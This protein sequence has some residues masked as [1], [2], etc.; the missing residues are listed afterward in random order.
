LST[1]TATLPLK[2]AFINRRLDTLDRVPQ[3]VVRPCRRTGEEEGPSLN[4]LIRNIGLTSLATLLAGT[5]PAT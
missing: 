2:A 1:D 5:T 3:P 4:E